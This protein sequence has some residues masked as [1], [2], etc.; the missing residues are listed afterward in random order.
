MMRPQKG[1]RL[2]IGFWGGILTA[3]A[4]FGLL[5]I[6][7][8]EP[9]DSSPSSSTYTV[10]FMDG[11]IK[12]S[13]IKV[14]SGRTVNRPSNPSKTGST[15]DN[16]Y[17]NSGFNILFDFG[18]S[19]FRDTTVYAKFNI[20]TYTVT[21]NADGGS[22]AP[23]TQNIAH[24]STV[25]QPPAMIKIGYGFGGWYKE[26]ALT[27]IWNFDTDTVT[28]DTTLY[29]K[30]DMNFHTVTFNADGGLP[31][32]EP[33][34]IAYGSK[35]LPPPAM[36]KTGHTFGGWYKE[37]AFTN[38]W[39]FNTDTVTNDIPLYAKWML[40][41][42]TVTFMDG[43]TELSTLTRSNVPHGSTVSK[44]TSDP[45]KYGYTF[46]NWYS[47]S[48]LTTPYNFDAPITDNTTIYAK[49]NINSYTVTFNAN[50]GLPAPGTQEINHGDKVTQPPVMTKFGY[51]FGGWYKEESLTNAWNFT[52]DT[53][54]SNISLYAKWDTNFYTVTFNADGGLPAP[55]PQNIAAGGKIP[56][57]PTMTKTGHTFGGWYKE[58][59]FANLWDFNTDNVIR[60][61]TL[62]A[63][64][65]L[66]T[67]TVTF[68]DGSTTLSSFTK[69]NVPHGS[70]ISRP[71]SDPSKYGYTFDN[72][73]LDSGLTV[74][75]N[76]DALITD[77]TIVYAKFNINTYTVSFMDGNTELSAFTQTNV[78]HGTTVNRPATNPSKANH[79][80][81]NWYS[82]SGLT[83]LFNFST[84]I[85]GNTTV[86]AKFIPVYTVSFNADGG[87]PAPVQQ[88]IKHGDK[89]T[90]PLAMTKTGYS[91][92]GWYKE[93][94][95]T[96]TWDFANDIVTGSITLYARWTSTISYNV[97]GG[98]GTAPTSQ[99]VSSGSSVTLPS[100]SGLSR[101]GY[102]FGGWNT[103]T[104]G[105][106]TNY[107]A[108][109]SYTPTG[110]ITLYAKWLPN[111][112]TITLNFAQII[113]QAPKLD[114]ITIYRS[115]EPRTATINLGTPG[116]YTSYEW[117][118]NNILLSNSSSIILNS[119]DIRYNMIGTQMLTLEV[120]K[121]GILYSTSISFTVN[122]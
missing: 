60:D 84:P 94:G 18:T 73:Y 62:Y 53:V 117:Y 59:A 91:F 4:I 2:G 69:D 67:Y 8:G 66:N 1:T 23:G 119:S 81:D 96:N 5:Y 32:P 116:Q 76:F 9:E 90:Q 102:T 42:Y 12:L 6:A 31:A 95:L 79:A 80:F 24:G 106:G 118:Y 19:I 10:T 83:T 38:L 120:V 78:T 92:G 15:F 27:N 63:K 100:D 111:T 64:W 37:A 93:V 28:S 29:A 57:P 26:T 85:T 115:K 39:D 72:W 49:F 61:T 25:T 121:D 17:A 7:C 43:S 50:G 98:T 109:S 99:T 113:D 11:S 89:V 51:G 30:W 68:M 122:E 44:P 108:G 52:T 58:A 33:Q 75:F 74:L 14:E 48:G 112:V 35:V 105:N 21:F 114:N 46:D 41:T 34:N 22:P 104:N 82:N 20:N 36:T 55:E 77:N 87:T 86:Y 97:N 3:L 101:T 71:A 70:T 54:I 65:M 56:P 16:W 45:T 40:N 107:N 13:D 103:Q 88:N 110:N 47:N